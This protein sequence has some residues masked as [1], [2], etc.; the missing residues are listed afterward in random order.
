MS[1]V[2]GFLSTWSN[3][4][5]TF[6]E[7]SPQTGEQYDKSATFNQLEST[8]QTAAPGSKW[9]GGAANAYGAANT[10]HGQVLGKL[11]GLDQRLSQHVNQSAEVVAA[12]RRDLESIR[13]WVMDASASAPQGQAGDKMRMAIVQK[14]LTQLQEVIK[15]SNGDINKIAGQMGGLRGEF[16]ALGNGQKFKNGPQT[17]GPDGKTDDADADAKRRQAEKDVQAALAGDREAARRVQDALK[18]IRPGQQLSAEQGSYLSQMQAQQHGMSIEALKTA[19]QRLGDQKHIIADSWQLMSNPNVQFPKTDTKLGA[20]DNPSQVANGGKSMLPESVQHALNRDGLN[21]IGAKLDPLSARTD[22]AH[23]VS[24]IAGIVHDGNQSLQQGT[25]LDR[26]MLD[27]SRDTLHDPTK[28]GFYGSL[29]LGNYDQYAEA[30]DNALGDVFDSAGRDHTSVTAEMTDA[31]TGQQFL[32]DLHTH[33]WADTGTATENRQSTHSL[34]DWIADDAHSPNEAVATQAGAAAHALAVNLDANHEKYLHPPGS[35]FGAE[36]NAANLDPEL[37]S[38]DAIAL[39]PYQDALV[40]DTSGVKGFEKIGATGDGDLHAAR[41][42]FAVIDSDPGAAK[43]FNAA[44]EHKML[45]HQQ[46]FTDAA[47]RGPTIADT[48]HGDLRHAANLLGALNGGA[49]QEATAR[50]L[51]GAETDKAIYNM[52][53][54]GLDYLFDNIPGHDLVPGIDMTRDTIES[55]ILGVNSDGGTAQPNIPVYN[56]QHALNATYYQMATAFDVSP[57]DPDIPGQ[58]FSPKGRLMSPGEI[59][60]AK[61]D[62]YSTA[63]ENYAHRHGYGD[64]GNRFDRYYHQGAGK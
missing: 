16:E 48:P 60:N 17:V 33:V 38:A 52:K 15:K 50:G 5:Q 37:I 19:E 20:L 58:F 9:S 22:N 35:P 57:G 32:T 61:L 24:T 3:A 44:A 55:G 14:G 1:V 36:P 34:L 23:D 28:S 40:G 46:A 30:R 43:A 49:E 25:E 54:A 31:E 39:A 42:V 10:E 27:W 59:T 41:N 12:G 11:A 4:R 47:T 18:G 2:D 45:A 6:G 53:K 8:V 13:K 21:S 63:L 56:A 26:G 62:D 64:L 29:G 7:G 51:Q